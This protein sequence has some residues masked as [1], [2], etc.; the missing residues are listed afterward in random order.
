MGKPG[1][2]VHILLETLICLIFRPVISVILNITYMYVK[3]Q[4]F[5]M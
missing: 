2:F 1:K 4:F 5:L 3:I